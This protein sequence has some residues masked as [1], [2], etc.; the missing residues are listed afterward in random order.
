MNWIPFRLE[1]N[2]SETMKKLLKLKD[3]NSNNNNGKMEKLKWILNSLSNEN[4]HQ[5]IPEKF[6]KIIV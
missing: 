5:I 3:E 6:I 2:E 4:L 1:K